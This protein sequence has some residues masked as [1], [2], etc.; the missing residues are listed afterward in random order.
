MALFDNIRWVI[1]DNLIA[2]KDLVNMYNILDDEGIEYEEVKVIPFSDELPEFTIDDKTNIYYGSTTFMN[3]LYKQLDKPEGLFFNHETFTMGNYIKEYGEYMLNSEAKVMPLSD[4]VKTYGNSE[5]NWFFRPDGDGKEFDGQVATGV[6]MVG[7]LERAVLNDVRLE[8]DHLMVVSPPYN[9]TKE[10][11]NYIVN[12]TV[13]TSSRYRENFRLSKSGT[14]IPEDMIK[15]VEDRCMEYQ[16]H[17]IFAMDIALCGG[18]YYIIECGCMNSVGFYDCDVSKFIKGVSDYV[19]AKTYTKSLKPRTGFETE[20]ISGAVLK[21]SGHK[22]DGLNNPL[23]D[24]C[25][26][27]VRFDHDNASILILNEHDK[28]IK[29]KYMQVLAMKMFGGLVKWA[30]HAVETGHLSSM[31]DERIRMVYE[32]LIYFF[33]DRDEYENAHYIK[34]Q[35]EDY[36]E[37]L[38]KLK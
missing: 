26:Y 28:T 20:V 2:E 3:N 32:D 17:A 16:P 4:V 14:D 25:N 8:P 38:D 24:D 33:A 6:E 18:D 30:E 35:L 9:I 23:I 29:T 31:R 1:Q 11:R 10:W 34:I 5:E 22:V 19:S 36:D 13:V 12:G 15:F 37:Y 27:F 21:D 7:V